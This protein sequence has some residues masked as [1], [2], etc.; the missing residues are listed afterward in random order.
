MTESSSTLSQPLRLGPIAHGGH[1]VARVDSRVIFVR[2]G[3]PGELVRVTLT[4]AEPGASFFRADVTEVLE[5]SPHRVTHFWEPAD[6]LLAHAQGRLPVGGAEFGHS[7]LDYQ[8]EL[9]RDVLAEQMR[10]LASID[11]YEKFNGA[12]VQPA[13]G[14]RADGLAWRTRMAYAVDAAGHLCMHPHRSEQLIPITSMPL[15]VDAINALNLSAANFTGAQRVEVAAAEGAAPLVLVAAGTVASQ[16]IAASVRSVSGDGATVAQ[17]NPQRSMAR[18]MGTVSDGG[19]AR[20]QTALPAELFEATPYGRLRVSSD[21][22]FQIHR[23]AVKTLGSE[24]ERLIIP[25]SGS[26]AAVADLYAGVGLFTALLA[27][28]VGPS[29]SVLSVEGYPLTSADAAA[30]FSSVPSVSV[31]RGKVEHVLARLAQDGK[32]SR[33]KSVVLDP[34][35]TGAGKQAIQRIAELTQ[36]A[37]VYVS[38]DPASFARDVSYFGQ[39]GFELIELTAWDLYPHT[40]HLETVAL[41][42]RR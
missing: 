3:L 1:V 27:G 34:P 25:H 26:G 11:I 29:G 17:W 23:S 24:V 33:F 39:Q 41:F 37:V 30:N 32:G 15:A 28:V 16:A 9:K 7:E 36:E 19:P 2:H 12:P 14:E 6:S 42:R 22:F 18:V 31:R 20:S 13:V 4:D 10:R 21:G 5:A 35:R 38:C 8:R 40:H